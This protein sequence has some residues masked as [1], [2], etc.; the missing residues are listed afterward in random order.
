M[1][2]KFSSKKPRDPATHTE[3]GIVSEDQKLAT[4]LHASP[5]LQDLRDAKYILFF[6]DNI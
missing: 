6:M 4:E 5:W 2:Y 3:T 1:V